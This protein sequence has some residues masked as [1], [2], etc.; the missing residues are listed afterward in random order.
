MLSLH[1]PRDDEGN[2]CVIYEYEGT[3]VNSVRICER[4]GKTANLKGSID[5]EI[6]VAEVLPHGSMHL[7]RLSL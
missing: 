1:E 5:P 2:C 7:R 3:T 4:D 6:L